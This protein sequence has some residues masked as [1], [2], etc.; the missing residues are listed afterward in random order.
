[1][2][3]SIDLGRLRFYYRDAYDANTTYEIN[4]VVSYGGSAYVYKYATNASGNLPT[5]TTYWSKLA[6]GSDFRGGWS[7]STQY[8]P[9]DIVVYGNAVYTAASAHTSTATA[10]GFFNDYASGYWTTLT[11]GFKWEGVW[12]AN[13][14]Y[15]PYD[16]VSYGGNTYLANSQFTSNSVSFANDTEWILFAQGSAGGEVAIQT[17]NSGKLLSTDGTSTQWVTNISFDAASGNT[18]QVDNNAWVG[19]NAQTFGATLQD[20]VAVYTVNTNDFAQIAFKNEGNDANTSTDIIAYMANGDDT[21]GWIDM[22]ITSENFT[23]PEFTITGKG[24]GYIFMEGLANSNSGGNLVLAT[25]GHGNNNYIIFA[26]GGLASDNTQMTIFPDQNVHVEITT[27]SVSPTTG[28][29]TVVGGIGTQGNINLLGDLTVQGSINV[30]GGAFQ[31]ETVTSVAPIFSTGAGA[32]GDLIERGFITEYKR[33]TS[34]YTFDIGSVESSNTTL[35]IRRLAY[36][37]STKS[38]TS[39]VATIDLGAAHSILSGE[40]IVVSNLGAPFD[41]TH[42]VTAV[43]ANT[44]SYAVTNA[45]IPTAGDVD[46]EVAPQVSN[47][48]IV[49]GDRIIIANSN[50]AS[51]NGSRDFVIAVSGNTVTANFT[52]VIANT[53]ATGDILVNSKTSFSGLVRGDSSEGN[54]WYLLGNIPPASSNGVH[55]PPTNDI[56][57][58]SNT[59]TYG[60]MKLNTLALTANGNTA[61]VISGDATISGNVAFTGTPTFTGGI[62]VQEMFEDVVDLTVS[63]YNVTADYSAGNI[64]YISHTGVNANYTL[65]LTNAPTDNGRIFTINVIIDQATTT[66]YYPN[67]I[68]INST[69]VDIKWPNGTA[70]TPTND[71]SADKLDIISFTVMRRSGSWTVFG[72][73]NLNF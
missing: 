29:L 8:F 16:I 67:A 9:N 72:S 64:F 14:M 52:T 13:T 65:N 20:A 41:G 31:A 56:D 55:V 62:R 32:T 38:L 42:T 23:D 66:G 33:T 28:A 5:D 17:S 11:Y 30:S 37:T 73:S 70:P 19:A 43:G 10:N 71:P 39:N 68:T 44:V 7:T 49:N 6:E 59:L 61:P 1:M 48:S 50:I 47:T 57:L 12:A 26:A 27:A 15:Q 22:G 35:T 51:I 69:A 54:N 53:L 25:G 36:G 21:T 63:A 34:D 2:S 46:G 45:D 24:D 60:T 58:T 40:E 3:Q 4:D 18:I